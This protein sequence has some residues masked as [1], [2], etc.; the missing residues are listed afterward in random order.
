MAGMDKV[1]F[2]SK[3][4]LGGARA[5]K[6]HDSLPN[7]DDSLSPHTAGQS[8]GSTR[9]SGHGDEAVGCLLLDLFKKNKQ[10][11]LGNSNGIQ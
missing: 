3:V 7:M 5:S 10:H 11:M 1:A 6:F 2:P 9:D 8:F 4:A